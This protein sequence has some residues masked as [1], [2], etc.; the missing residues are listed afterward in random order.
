MYGR[1]DQNCGSCGTTIMRIVQAQRSTFYCPTC[2][3]MT[4]CRASN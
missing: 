1:A 2:Q 4:R 3:P